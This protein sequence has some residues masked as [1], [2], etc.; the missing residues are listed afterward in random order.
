M[1]CRSAIDCDG[2]SMVRRVRVKSKHDKLATL[3]HH[4]W[5]KAYPGK[6][7]GCVEKR[8]KYTLVVCAAERRAM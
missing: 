6:G 1:L 7:V 2:R 4:H 8:D 3:P 5:L